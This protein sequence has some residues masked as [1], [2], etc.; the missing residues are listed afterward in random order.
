MIYSFALDIILNF[1][2][3]YTDEKTSMIVTSPRRIAWKYLRGFFFI[4]LIA[5]IP[6]GY[7]LTSSS[8]AVSNKLGKLGR[9]P[10]LVK[11]V[12][13]GKSLQSIDRFIASLNHSQY[14]S[15]QL[16][17]SNYYGSIGYTI[18]LSSSRYS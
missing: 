7:I 9:L 2:T 14:C 6:F 8:F 5:T 13:A 4:D 18:S 1:L 17:C 10:K 11:F 12:R 3:T 16:A 15:L